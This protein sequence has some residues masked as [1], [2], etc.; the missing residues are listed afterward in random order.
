MLRTLS[1]RFPPLVWTLL[2]A[3]CSASLIHFTH[4][5]EYIAV[6]P[7]MPAWL[8]REKVYI[9]WLAVTGVGIVGIALSFLGR[10]VASAL[11]LAAY[12]AL[13][14]GGLGHY[15]L[16]LCSEHTFA[17]NFTIWF[18]AVTGGGLAVSAIRLAASSEP[19][20]DSVDPA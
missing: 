10:R 19:G 8:T 17:M 6:Y 11:W 15:S 20:P 4:N 14:L 18:E 1:A 5:A 3:Y 16:A 9:A 7:N 13:G 12:G 2:A